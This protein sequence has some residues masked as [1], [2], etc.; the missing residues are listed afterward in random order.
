MRSRRSAATDKD[1]FDA[2]ITVLNVGFERGGVVTR[3]EKRGDRFVEEPYEVYAPR[4]LAGIAGLKDTLEDRSLPLFMLRKRRNE[5]VAR[6]NSA[7]DAE[8]QA[9]RDQCALACL[10]HV[11]NLVAAYDSAPSVLER[12]GVDDRA[13]D[14]WSPLI[15]VTMVA[16]AEDRGNRM[17]Q[18]LELA[19]DLGSVRDAD[20][21]GGT[22][23]RLLGVLEAIRAELG[24]APAPADLLKAIRERPD[25]DWLKNT[26]RLAGLLNPLGIVRQQ[27]RDGGRRRWCYVLDGDQ[28]AD[29]QARYGSGGNVGDEPEAFDHAGGFSSVPEPVTTDAS[30][31]NPHE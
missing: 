26:R 31:D 1:R 7:T 22:T 6:L 20:A 29:L 8:A 9:L 24:E 5:T 19:R 4:V 3:L 25:W 12:E 2:L 27:I 13:V 16:D 10:T 28:L 17:R 15:A 18:L 23:A 14:L 11:Q 21:E 30:G